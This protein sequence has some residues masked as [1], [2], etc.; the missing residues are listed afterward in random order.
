MR[1]ACVHELPS[2][3]AKRVVYEHCRHLQRWGHSVTVYESPAADCGFLDVEPVV[4]RVVRIQ[5]PWEEPTAGGGCAPAKVWG[6]LRNARLLKRNFERLSARGQALAEE[7]DAEGYDLTYVHHSVRERAPS[8]LRFL[9][10]PSVYFCQE[11]T[12]ELFEGPL[13][14]A[15]EALP[16]HSGHWA[17]APLEPPSAARLWAEARPRQP[18][19]SR[20]NNYRILLERANTRAASL[21]LT[22]SAFSAESLLRAHGCPS[23]FAPL[24]VDTEYF[25][26][27]P[28]AREDWLLAVSA[29]T[30][31]KGF[32]FLL[33]SVAQ[34]PA[35]KRLPLVL[36]GDRAQ[37]EEVEILEGMAAQAGLEVTFRHR[38]SE[39]ELRDLYCR[40]RLLLYAPYLEPLGLVALEAMAC[41]LPVLGVREGGLRE[42][43]VD[44]VTGRLV[45]RDEGLYARALAELLAAPEQLEGMGQA[46]ADYV[47]ARWT[48][49]ASA[50]HLLGLFREL[51]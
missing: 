33:R 5:D 26:P 11:P 10:T 48:W 6:A 41:R 4:E 35:D 15:V 7:I 8:V 50:Q 25:R 3:G 21:V 19:R 27:A 46:A 9:R 45:E 2:G 42:T 38:V 36:V 17:Q 22:N 16:D 39:E 14:A 32:R 20:V 28:V 37:P 1:I 18:I 40:A 49:E 29:F 31:I 47:R 34:L 30:P 13:F 44:G 24:G 51:E 12:R 43:I 23:R